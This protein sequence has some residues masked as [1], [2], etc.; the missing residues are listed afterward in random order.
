MVKA[1][2]L[3][4][5]DGRGPAGQPLRQRRQILQLP[6]IGRVRPLSNFAKVPADPMQ[7]PELGSI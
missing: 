3:R 5:N 2:G 1:A 7:K 4:G 6:S